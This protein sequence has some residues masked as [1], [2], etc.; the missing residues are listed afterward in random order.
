MTAVGAQCCKPDSGRFFFARKDKVGRFCAC[1]SPGSMGSL[2][3]IDGP[4]TS[5]LQRTFERWYPGMQAVNL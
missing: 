4:S 1:Y 3:P 5:E 2:K